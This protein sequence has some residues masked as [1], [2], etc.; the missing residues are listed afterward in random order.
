[1]PDECLRTGMKY[2]LGK[3]QSISSGV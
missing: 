1:M 3:S 2:L